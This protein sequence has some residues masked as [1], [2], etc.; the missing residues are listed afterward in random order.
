[1]KHTFVALAVS[2]LFISAACSKSSP[3]APSPAAGGSASTPMSGEETVEA[4]AATDSTP[5]Q[6]T[7]FPVQWTLTR[8][9]CPAL[10]ADSVTGTGTS[11]MMVR[12]V[13]VAGGVSQI[14]LTEA[15]SGT[16]LDSNGG[17]FR[18]SSANTRLVLAG[19][20]FLLDVTQSFNLVGPG[21]KEFRLHVGFVELFKSDANG[22][23][24]LAEIK[25]R[26]D[27]SCVPIVVPV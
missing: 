13:Q 14:N 3:T 1:V 16:A 23:I 17:Q 8:A 19:P 27:V 5:A 25:P 21:G 10:W 12:V 18:F 11:H 6:T 24:F 7:T 26:G 15:T 20:Q 4:I 2:S 9:T 22:N